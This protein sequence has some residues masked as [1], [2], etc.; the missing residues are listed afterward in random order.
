VGSAGNPLPPKK[1]IFAMNTEIKPKLP[2]KMKLLVAE[3][4]MAERPHFNET[5][6][7][8]EEILKAVSNNLTQMP[9]RA[10]YGVGNISNKVKEE[11]IAQKQDSVYGEA[12]RERKRKER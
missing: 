4:P 10:H 9:P 6:E 11:K 2:T 3:Q 1:N 5:A 8:L 7:V 12:E